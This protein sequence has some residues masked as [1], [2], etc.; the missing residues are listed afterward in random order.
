[1]QTGFAQ[2]QSSLEVAEIKHIEDFKFHT[3]TLQKEILVVRLRTTSVEI[4]N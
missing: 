3:E 1:M 4:S 2:L